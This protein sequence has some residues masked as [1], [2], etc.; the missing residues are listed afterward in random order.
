MTL[1]KTRSPLEKLGRLPVIGHRLASWPAR[2]WVQKDLPPMVI[3]HRLPAA[4]SPMPRLRGVAWTGN[5]LVL[6][7]ILGLGTWSI[8]APLKSAAIASGIVEPE[9]SRKTIQHL[10]GG[11]VRQILVRNGD[12]VTAGQVLF[13]LDDTK[14]RSER[15]SL[16][17][18]LWDAEAQHARLLAEQQDRDSVGYP[19]GLL[20]LANDHPRLAAIVVGQD[21]IFEAR[22]RVMQS[23][24]AITHGKMQQV[25]QEIIGLGA[26]KASL[27][28]RA[29]IARQELESVSSLITKGVERKNRLFNLGREKAGLDGQIGDVDAQIAR[30]Y[31]VIAESQAGLVKLQSDRLNEVAE[32]L[33]DT[34]NRMLQLGEQ[35]RTVDDQLARTE[36]RAPEDGVIV[37]LRIHTGGGVVGA[38]EPLVDLVPRD[39]RLIISAHVRPEDINLVHAGLEAQVHLLP[40]N[41]RRVPLLKG[42]VDYVSADRLIDKQTGQS[43]YA[44]TI[45]VTDERLAKMSKVELIAGMPAQALIET[46]QSSVAFY[47]LRPLL[48]SFNRAFRED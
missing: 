31:Q 7:F 27:G 19:A 6:T 21:R 25:Q 29:D 30:A 3:D 1:I 8:L 17:G 32:G 41:Q 48:D 44:T 38:G 42:V 43:Y 16:Q 47:A 13:M 22:R 26:Q 24:I 34:E 46:G 33:R 14:A 9:T 35:L 5:L 45:R 11:I 10:E 20:T 4:A 28:D 18:Q 37:D 2:A 40:Y 39:G 23:E 36:V 15:D 12:L